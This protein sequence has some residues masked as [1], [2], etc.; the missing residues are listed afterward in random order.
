MRG[1]V[2]KLIDSS[3]Y[4]IIKK[5]EEVGDFIPVKSDIDGA[6]FLITTGDPVMAS[7]MEILDEYKPLTANDLK[8][9]CEISG[10]RYAMMQEPPQHRVDK[11][12]YYRQFEQRQRG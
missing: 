3:D 2:T 4:I 6:V 1:D 12:P 9:L 8:S 7:T 11:R 10:R 5:L